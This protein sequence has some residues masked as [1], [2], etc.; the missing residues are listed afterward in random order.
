M[1]FTGLRS[2]HIAA[3]AAIVVLGGLLLVRGPWSV[4]AQESQNAPETSNVAM[5]CAPGQQAVVRQSV[6]NRALE[7]NIHCVTARESIGYMDQF[8]QPYGQPYAQPYPQRTAYVAPITQPRASYA[9][10]RQEVARPIVR[11]RSWQ[12]T[13]LVIGGSAGAG[14]GIG[15]LIGGKKGAAIGG[16]AGAAGGTGAVM[17]G[18]NKDATIAAGVPLTVRLTAPA[19]VTIEK[20]EK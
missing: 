4:G 14:A 1:P 19:T 11:K 17:A 7:V 5:N 3:A 15:A 9:P 2:T 8:G 20:D 13:A 18:G 16:A 10:V 12:K 6:V